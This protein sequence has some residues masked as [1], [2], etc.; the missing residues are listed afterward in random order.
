M[1]AIIGKLN[2]LR[3]TLR[4]PFIPVIWVGFVLWFVLLGMLI[5]GAPA[6]AIYIVLGFLFLDKLLMLTQFYGALAAAKAYNY[7]LQAVIQTQMLIEEKE[8]LD[9]MKTHKAE[10]E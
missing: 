4:I 8:R 10:E 6:L 7:T 1:K 3:K 5:L 9:H 2:G